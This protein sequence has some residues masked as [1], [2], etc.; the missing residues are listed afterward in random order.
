MKQKV[1]VGIDIGGTNTKIGVVNAD[2]KILANSRIT[3]TDYPKIA[4]FVAALDAEIRRLLEKSGE[5]ELAAIGI[6]APNGN[7]LKG[8]IEQAPNLAWKGVVPLCDMLRKF[9]PIPVVLTNDANAAAEVG[10]E[11][12]LLAVPHQTV[13]ARIASASHRFYQLSF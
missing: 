4:A 10:L 1:T 13:L 11:T 7:Y 3:T 12:R 2:G 9:F 6:G 5:V 8:T